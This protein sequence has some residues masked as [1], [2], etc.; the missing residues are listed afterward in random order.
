MFFNTFNT[1]KTMIV[2]AVLT[3]GG[4]FA[5]TA[6]AQTCVGCTTQTTTISGSG[7]F[8]G[9]GNGIFN[10]QEGGVLVE[11]N[12]WSDT[13]TQ[14][15]IA[16]SPCD[17]DCTDSTFSFIGTSGQT[18]SVMSGAFGNTPGEAVQALSEGGSFSNL[19][20]NLGTLT[21]TAPANP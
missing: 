19:E 4:S 8:G 12:G 10:G 5:A 13:Q 1:F 21:T 20:F 17:T 16:G 6:V 7:G 11:Q 3:L 15:N 9:F 2:F 14:F 18:T